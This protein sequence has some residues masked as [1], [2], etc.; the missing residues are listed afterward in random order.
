MINSSSID[1][2][3]KVNAILRVLKE[4][5]EAVGARLIGRQL[6]E[7]GIDLSER[8]VRYH[9]KLMDERGLTQLVGRDGR[10]ITPA[11]IEELQDALVAD[12]VGLFMNRI[13]TVSFRTTFDWRNRSGCVPANLSIFRK[14]DFPRALKAMAGAFKAGISVGNLVAVAD[15]GEP[16]REDYSEGEGW[17]RDGMQCRGRWGVAEIRSAHGFKVRRN[18]ADEGPEAASFRR[19]D[20]LQRDFSGPVG[21]I[22][23][24]QDDRRYRGSQER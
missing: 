6:K 21:G 8:A 5:P 18:T 22:H 17:L 15:A 12:K 19:A 1:V 9:L 10:Q 13:E 24:G 7:Q 14:D 16:G 20:L 4:S 11:G 2:E 3:R 23:Q